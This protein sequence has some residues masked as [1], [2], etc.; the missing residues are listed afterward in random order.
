MPGP[1]TEWRV[2]TLGVYES[3]PVDLTKLMREERQ[4]K[5]REMNLE[6]LQRE[7]ARLEGLGISSLPVRVQINRQ[8]SFSFACF[9]FTLIGIPLGIRTHRRE[10]SIGVALALM[11]VLVYYTFL[12]MGDAWAAREALHPQII[13]W[14]PNFLFQALGAAL[15]YRANGKA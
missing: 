15:L 10:T 1:A 12:I 4:P 6:Q 5:L 2:A 14:L 11:L 3:D 8:I 7:R 9:G 13:V